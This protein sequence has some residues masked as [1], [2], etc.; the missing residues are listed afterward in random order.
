MPTKQPPKK[1]S[2]DP[3]ARLYQVLDDALCY[4][5]D[6][7][8]TWTPASGLAANERARDQATIQAAWAVWHEKTRP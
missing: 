8:T 2:A 4:S 3:P 6:G 1:D 5:D 7:G